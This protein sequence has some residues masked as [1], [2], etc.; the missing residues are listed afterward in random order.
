MKVPPSTS[1]Q[2]RAQAVL[3]PHVY[4]ALR[5]EA[6]MVPVRLRAPANR[7]AFRSAGDLR[8][9][10]GAGANGRVGWVNV[11]AFPGPGVTC[12]HDCRWSLPFPDGSVK[13]LFSEHF[14]EHLERSVEVPRFLAEVRRVLAPQGVVRLIVPDVELYLRAY[15]A[16]DWK[17]LTRIRP[18]HGRRDRWFDVEYETPLELAQY[19]MRQLPA[20]PHQYG[21]DAETLALALTEAGFGD[22]RRRTF[23]ESRIPELALD[24][25]ERASESLY[26]EASD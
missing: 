25:A 3:P 16:Q 8:V 22:V 20:E 13:M 19:V 12:R 5:F 10:V 23:G 24:L 14:L 11:D 6:A 15:C 18:L 9:N 1:R 4:H 7:R 26:V 21:Y 2:R 17:A